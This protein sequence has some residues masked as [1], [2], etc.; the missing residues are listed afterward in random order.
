[1]HLALHVLGLT[2][3][4][5]GLSM[6]VVV[7]V[8]VALVLLICCW[9]PGLVWLG[10]AQVFPCWWCWC[11]PG[12]VFTC[13]LTA[14]ETVVKAIQSPAGLFEARHNI[15]RGNRFASSVFRVCGTVLENVVHEKLQYLSSFRVAFATRSFDPPSAHYAPYSRL[16][17]T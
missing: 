2:R 15:T 11:F 5:L 10:R 1:M 9:L 4:G 6:L 3:A 16:S 17:N 12:L 8:L 7:M 14:W 13:G